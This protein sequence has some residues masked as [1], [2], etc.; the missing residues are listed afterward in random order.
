MKPLLYGCR[1]CG[2]CR[3]MGWRASS[4]IAL[5]LLWLA[6]SILLAVYLFV[7]PAGR[8]SRRATTTTRILLRRKRPTSASVAPRRPP[9]RLLAASVAP[10]A[11]AEGDGGGGARQSKPSL[12]TAEGAAV[13]AGFPGSE[14]ATL[15]RWGRRTKATRIIATR[16]GMALLRTNSRHPSRPLS[17]PRWW[18]A[19]EPGLIGR[20][21]VGIRRQHRRR[22]PTTRA[23]SSADCS[24][25]KD[26][27]LE[28][29]PLLGTSCYFFCPAAPLSPGV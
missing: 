3:H 13:E 21:D 5:C 8:A 16:T 28:S 20:R 15:R 23:S 7:C 24:R 22:D 14:G 2:C 10:A 9:Q 4:S 1:F 27:W 19:S 11:P 26:V 6:N 25:E 29:D 12:L 18:T 17:P